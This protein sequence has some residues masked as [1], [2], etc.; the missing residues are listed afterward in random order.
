MQNG[1]HVTSLNG[2][3]AMQNGSPYMHLLNGQHNG[4]S[5]QQMQNLKSMFANAQ[6][7]SGQ[8]MNN[9]NANGGRSLPASF[10]GHPSLTSTCNWA[11]VRMST[12]SY[13]DRR[14]GPRYLRHCSTAH[15]LAMQL[16]LV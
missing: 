7:Q 13:R 4:L 15:H 10:M 14:N 11:L 9:M 8:D 6:M 16:T 5:M 2:F 12:S 1:Y 3:L